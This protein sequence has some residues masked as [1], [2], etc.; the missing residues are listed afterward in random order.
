MTV[1]HSGKHWWNLV[2]V[3]C[4]KER[5]NAITPGPRFFSQADGKRANAITPGPRLV[6]GYST[7]ATCPGRDCHPS[8]GAEPTTTTSAKSPR[9]TGSSPLVPGS[10]RQNNTGKAPAVERDCHPSSPGCCANE[11]QCICSRSAFL[12]ATRPFR[13]NRATGT[14]VQSAGRACRGASSISSLGLPPPPSKTQNTKASFLSEDLCVLCFESMPV[15]LSV[16][17]SFFCSCVCSLTLR[18]AV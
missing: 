5:A 13:R 12:T 2:V 18:G 10:R 7:S 3:W 17:C 1:A 16:S 4:E 6:I 8:P 14:S 9:V 11:H 15:Y